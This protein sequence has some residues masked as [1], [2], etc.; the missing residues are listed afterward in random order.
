[1]FTDYGAWVFST[2]AWEI[3]RYTTFRIELDGHTEAN[4]QT[5]REQ[6]TPWELSAERANAARR[7]LVQ[8]GVDAR[9]ICKVSGYA[10]TVPMP[11][12]P[13]EAEVN[14]R[15]TVLLKLKESTDA[16]PDSALNEL[17]HDTP[18]N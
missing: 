17:P 8:S 1:V 18:A 15:V 14:R 6:H 13:P 9:Q 2:L 10:G 16:L 5:N 11:G 3:S 7:K 4:T 12:Y